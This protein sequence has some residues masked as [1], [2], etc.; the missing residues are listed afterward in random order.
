MADVIS[1]SP[2]HGSVYLV[3]LMV[4]DAV[5][6]QHGNRCWMAQTT[7]A[8]KCRLSRRTVGKALSMLEAQGRLIRDGWGING[9]VRWTWKAGIHGAGNDSQGAKGFPSCEPSSQPGAKGFPMGCEGISH[10]PNRTQVEP[11]PGDSLTMK[12]SAALAR[13]AREKLKP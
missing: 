7:L 6:D 13:A 10:K 4:A 5:N 1:N 12:E 2:N 3:E 9:V 8:D 11:K